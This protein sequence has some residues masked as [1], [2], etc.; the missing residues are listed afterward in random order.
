MT[1]APL[2]PALQQ[3]M[4]REEFAIIGPAELALAER[5]VSELAENA[6]VARSTADAIYE[7]TQGWPLASLLMIDLERR[8]H[9]PA[10]CA[11]AATVPRDLLLSFLVHR[12]I[13]RLKGL[14]RDAV[15]VAALRPGLTHPE[16]VR[17]LGDDVDDFLWTQLS[18]FP[19][20]ERDAGGVRVHPEVVRLLRV[21]FA[22]LMK[23][24]YERILHVLTG[25]GDYVEAA[26]LA[27][28]MD[29]VENAAAIIDAAPPYMAAPIRVYDYERI[30]DRLDRA[31]ITRYPNLWIATI[32]FRNF[33][34][35]RKAFIREAE[36]VYYCM[37]PSATPDQRAAVTL[38]L[39]SAYANAGR[40]DESDRLVE[41]SL[42]GFARD[43]A[44]ARA[45]I[46]NFVASM[47]GI[48]GRF[49]DARALA[50]EAAALASDDFG[51]NLTLQYI[52]AHEAT[53][54]GKIDR[55]VV[56]F[57]EL[58]RRQQR[59]DMPLY[60]ALTACNAA[61]H[62]WA[63]GDDADFARYVD[64]LGDA[65]TPGIERG[66]A[67]LVDNA[68]GRQAQVDEE[69]PFPVA[70]AIAHLFRLGNAPDHATA[71]DAARCAAR[72]ADL[73]GDPYVQ[74]L[75][76]V[77][78]Y[79]LDHRS[80]QLEADILRTIVAPMEAPE[81]K[82]ALDGVLNG[83]HAGILEPFVK[84]RVQRERHPSEAKLVVELLAG[85]V[86]LGGVPIRLSDK[87]FELLALLASTSGTCSRNRIG[88]ALWEHLDPEEWSNNL[89]VTLSRLRAKLGIRDAVI[90]SNSAYRLSPL[91]EVDLRSVEA[92]VRQHQSGALDPKLRTIASAALG[93]YRGGA[94]ARYERYPWMHGLIARI[95]EMVCTLGTM[96][97]TDALR[98]GR[99][100]EALSLTREIQAVDQYYEAACETA[101]NVHRA[102]GDVDAARREFRRYAT[103]LANELGATPSLRLAELVRAPG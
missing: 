98:D 76:H 62:T 13:A 35:D 53:Y 70:R 89:K 21:R 88:E 10:L 65:L 45:T 103:A 49:R 56:I 71:L 63:N 46:L 50:A 82:Y 102:R 29:D 74:I 14:L 99:L 40:S 25:E 4:A 28:D 42:G 100:D 36:T 19:F 92:I 30:I 15:A 48:E 77:A 78:V 69:F 94:I 52:D 3:A 91:I 83:G 16:L 60:L 51:Q 2:P 72:A 59:D 34:V 58:I 97:A 79:L 32:P 80:R 85:A 86:T 96:L 41:D 67:S 68:R 22:A 17:I 5:T 54:R 9:D 31:L 64:I 81:L 26:R 57:D 39:A 6:G 24:S 47:R 38:I 66:F 8:D 90:V 18:A 23:S 37:P 73:R 7:T 33:A 84:Q 101:I 95:D 61:F 1:R 11:E 55:I 93:A 75:A 20:V 27:L 43:S 12:T 87:E 44:S